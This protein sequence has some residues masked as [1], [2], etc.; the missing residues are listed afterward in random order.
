MLPEA[1]NL[2]HR[3]L[4]VAEV[5]DESTERI[6]RYLSDMKVPVNVATVQHFKAA[7]GKEILAQ[8]FLV[9]PESAVVN[10][11]SRYNLGV[12]QAQANDAGVGHLYGHLHERARGILRAYPYPRRVFYQAT[13]DERNSTVIIIWPPDSTATKG[14]SFSV[15]GNRV[16]RYLGITED[17]LAKS[18]PDDCRRTEGR[19]WSG[20]VPEERETWFTFSGYFQ[21]TEEIDRF[22]TALGN[23]GN[24]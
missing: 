9:P 20:A 11:T 7:D 14:L 3:S 19:A 15:R 12:A 8:V 1:L 17:Q 13:I 10:P 23:R 18:L 16:M 21:T 2:N 5:M 4:I 22:L 24:G 6:V